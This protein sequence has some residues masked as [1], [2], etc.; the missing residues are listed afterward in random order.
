MSLVFEPP[1]RTDDPVTVKRKLEKRANLKNPD[2]GQ[3]PGEQSD[4][5]S[6]AT[7]NKR[8]V[9]PSGSRSGQLDDAPQRTKYRHFTVL[10]AALYKTLQNGDYQ[11]ASRIFGMMLRF[12]PSGAR[13]AGNHVDLRKGELWSVGLEILLRRPTRTK[14][15]SANRKP[16]EVSAEAASVDSFASD[17]GFENAKD[18]LEKMILQYPS[19]KALDLSARESART[20]PPTGNLRSR[21]G[22]VTS[23]RLY[24]ILVGLEIMQVDQRIK[25]QGESLE[26]S[27]EIYASNVADIFAILRRL[28]DIMTQPPHDKHVVLYGLAADVCLWAS[29][30]MTTSGRE[31][32]RNILELR[33]QAHNL[34]ARAEELQNN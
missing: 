9:L 12:E 5:T 18:L 4:G 7:D 28:Q 17:D 6:L 30:Y 25:S 20:P 26:S 11:R 27:E 34:R 2:S 29:D 21:K 22:L 31:D 14:N 19:S 3:Q 32:Q 23:H 33:S 24:P 15:L 10:N 8:D 13:R 16:K 1:F